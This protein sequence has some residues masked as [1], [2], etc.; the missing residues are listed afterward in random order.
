M[1]TLFDC[2]EKF[3][4]KGE[5]V[6]VLD[7]VQYSMFAL[8]VF[9]CFGDKIDE[10]QVREIYDFQMHFKSNI[11]GF[12]LLHFW[13]RL[14]KIILYKRWR[15]YYQ[16]RRD[17]ANIFLPLIMNAQRSS[18]LAKLEDDD[19][20]LSYVDTLLD[21]VIPEKGKLNDEQLI[22]LCSEFLTSGTDSSSTA[23]QWIMATLVKHQEIQEKLFVEIEQVVERDQE[24][25][26]DDDL[27]QMP[28]LKAVVL[29][30]LRR[31]PPAHM[32]L[33]H[34]VTR[35][36]VLRDYLVPAKCPVNFMVA[37]MGWDP[38][39]WEDP[40]VFKPER[41]LNTPK[42]VV[43]F[44]VT[45]SKE[46]KMMPFGVGRRMC[47]AYGFAMLHL[48]YFVANLIWKF[49]WFADDTN[50]EVNLEEKLDFT[51]VMKHPLRAQV[52]PRFNN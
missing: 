30:G 9:N 35:D 44:D 26:K 42:G 11:G 15:E 39:V 27:K 18:Q 5:P 24:L 2:L 16:L 41:F 51:V 31:H 50:G 36:I 12:N 33:P 52:S 28:Y 38:D 32:V 3:S 6:Q 7:Q 4:K 29:E 46:I 8:L 43:S 49:K 47:P 48:E 19:N 20:I 22:S 37:E 17:Q 1:V 21:L 34:K 45:G 13:P 23:L 14:T 10:G 25:I 40:M